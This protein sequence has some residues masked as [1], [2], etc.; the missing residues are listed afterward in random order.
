M[1][2]EKQNFVDDQILA[3]DHLNH[4]EDGIEQLDLN[5]SD[6]LVYSDE[7]SYTF[8]INEL[9]IIEKKKNV[10]SYSVKGLIRVIPN[11]SINASIAKKDGSIESLSTIAAR[12]EETIPSVGLTNIIVAASEDYSKFFQIITNAR[13]TKDNDLI[14]DSSNNVIVINHPDIDN[15]ESFTVTMSGE[16]NIDDEKI[17]D[18]RYQLVNKFE[19]DYWDNKA[20]KSE[21]FSGDYNDLTNKPEILNSNIT[22]INANDYTKK[23]INNEIDVNMSYINEYGDVNKFIY[24]SIKGEYLNKAL[25]KSNDIYSVVDVTVEE[26]S[27]DPSVQEIYFN[28]DSSNVCKKII[29]QENCILEK[30]EVYNSINVQRI[31]LL[32]QVNEDMMLNLADK[33]IDRNG[34]AWGSIII[35]DQELRRKIE[36]KF[37]KKDWYFG[38]P[39]IYDPV[40]RAKIQ[41]YMFDSGIVDIWESA[42]YGEDAR[43]GIIDSGL[44]L[45]L[46]ELDTTNFLGAIDLICN[47]GKTRLESVSIGTSTDHYVTHGSCVYSIIAGKGVKYYGVAPKCSWYFI[48][49]G[50]EDG[51]ASYDAMFQVPIVAMQN[52]LEFCTMSYSSPI[53]SSKDYPIY[54]RDKLYYDLLNEYIEDFN[55][56]FNTSVKNNHKPLQAYKMYS[57][58]KPANMTHAAYLSNG[59]YRRRDASKAYNAAFT[60]YERI[61]AN[62]YANHYTTFSGSSC[63]TPIMTGIFILASNIFKKKHGRR[64]NKYELIDL[65]KNRTDPCRD[66]GG[67]LSEDPTLV[68]YGLI[69]VMAYRDVSHITIQCIEREDE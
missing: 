5:K 60:S 40:E 43:L 63:A 15:I 3:A 62:D 36:D 48:K 11:K 69:N 44:R 10:Y 30:I 1:S 35:K 67:V 51:S 27:I 12:V 33:L 66:S 32:N 4:I 59:V 61:N 14:Y 65:L 64:P 53:I 37:I 47:N 68:G 49:I 19:K 41:Q 21:L 26:Y 28:L 46:A 34:M 24:D 16:F 6:K 17:F 31:H 20:D 42:E 55:G 39:K 38:S 18:D 23:V 45:D 50:R 58:W 13:V 25:I 22:Y 57:S 52:K 8:N 7:A 54:K 9:E 2:Y 29:A 56:V